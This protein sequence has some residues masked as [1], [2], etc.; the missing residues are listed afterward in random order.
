MAKNKALHKDTMIERLPIPEAGQVDYIDP[1]VPDFGIR[2]N[3]GG[4]R[5]WWVRVK[6]KGQRLR[7]TI[8]RWPVYSR[9]DA[10][11]T[12]REWIK[13]ADRGV[14]PRARARP[15]IT[16]GDLFVRYM[17]RQKAK[18][19]KYWPQEKA[20]FHDKFSEWIGREAR[21]LERREVRERF[22]TLRAVNGKQA[23]EQARGLLG[24]IY[25]FGLGED[26]VFEDPTAGIQRV[27]KRQARTRTLTDE[28]IR[29]L[30]P[31]WQEQEGIG[32]C[33]LQLILLL[34]TRHTETLRIRNENIGT[35]WLTIEG[36]YTKNSLTHVAPVTPMVRG[37]LDV[38]AR[39]SA[40]SPWLF[41]Q[42]KNAEKPLNSI[43]DWT[44][45]SRERTGIV[46]TPHD[47]RRT[48]YS[49]MRRLGIRDEVI[50]AYFNHQ[51]A[52]LRKH[53]D[54]YHYAPE[55]QEAAA[56]WHADLARI[57]ERREAGK[58]VA[59]HRS[60]STSGSTS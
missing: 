11:E 22:D 45:L 29:T 19:L 48:A 25:R 12:A 57:L 3:R 34:G 40:S 50:G 31:F 53:Y 16:L 9:E 4:T 24:R 32:Y 52:G 7:L 35:E 37:V 2:V 5:T 1:G 21:S 60:T 18:G 15:G 36:R 59:I 38:L 6:L 13:L 10:W 30:W 20:D 46:F 28:E 23:A 44:A 14:D 33:A 54:H 8:G 58:V 42:E 27:A 17:E 41:P 39:W 56:V 49:A 47:L 51:K 55:R 43:H 26:L